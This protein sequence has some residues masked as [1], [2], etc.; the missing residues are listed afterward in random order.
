MSCFGVCI[1]DPD[2]PVLTPICLLIFEPSRKI[3][4][5]SDSQSF[6]GDAQR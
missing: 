3:D 4:T 5:L 2:Q 6:H 1:A